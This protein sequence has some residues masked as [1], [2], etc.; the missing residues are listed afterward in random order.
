MMLFTSQ[1]HERIQ[2]TRRLPKSQ[3]LLKIYLSIQ[4][5]G[6][7]LY[8]FYSLKY[9]H[10]F[11]LEIRL[12]TLSRNQKEVCSFKVSEA[13]QLHDFRNPQLWYISLIDACKT[14]LSQPC[15]RGGYQN[16]NN[17]SDC[18]CPDGFSGQLCDQIAPAKNGKCRITAK[19][20][21]IS[22]ITLSG[23]TVHE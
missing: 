20:Q 15:Q 23:S 9:I 22:L 17:C 18:I 10:N 4:S 8:S 3:Q 2:P 6:T 5:L 1:L 13:I 16:P 12:N 19:V 21:S 14:P 7:S 11:G